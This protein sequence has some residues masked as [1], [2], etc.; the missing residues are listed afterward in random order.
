MRKKVQTLLTAFSSV[1]ANHAHHHISHKMK[2]KE[3][4]SKLAVLTPTALRHNCIW[5]AVNWH[6]PQN[7]QFFALPLSPGLSVCL[8]SL[9]Q[10]LLFHCCEVLLETH[11]DNKKLDRV[12]VENIEN[13]NTQS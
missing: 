11:S 3:A 9:R 6:T 2:N 8:S 7:V 5:T 1:S 10:P 13:F 12:F 4:S